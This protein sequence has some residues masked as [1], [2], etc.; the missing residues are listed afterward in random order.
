MVELLVCL[1]SFFCGSICM[2][3]ALCIQPEVVE[4]LRKV[5]TAESDEKVENRGRPKGSK[6]KTKTEVKLHYMIAFDHATTSMDKLRKN[7]DKLSGIH[8]LNVEIDVDEI[9]KEAMESIEAIDYVMKCLKGLCTPS[10][11]ILLAYR[12]LDGHLTEL[13]D[14]TRE[15]YCDQME[16]SVCAIWSQIDEC[17]DMFKTLYGTRV[18]TD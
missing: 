6:N 13:Y 11:A 10:E 4:F 14:V 5:Y 12:S 2:L 1:N 18:T 8:D 15:A 7:I 9:R 17:M 16:E 3:I